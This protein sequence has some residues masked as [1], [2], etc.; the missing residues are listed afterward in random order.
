MKKLLA[1]ILCAF[2]VFSLCACTGNGSTGKKVIKWYTVT[3]DQKDQDAVFEKFNEELGEL[4]TGVEVEFYRGELTDK[5]AS[6]MAA[7]EQIDIAWTGYSFNMVDQILKKSYQPLDELI[8][9]YAPNIQQEIKDY[10]TEYAS[11]SYQGTLYA[12]PNVQPLIKESPMIE[13][14][15]SLWEFF[16]AEAFSAARAASPY[17]TED[18]LKVIDDYLVKV[19]ASGLMDSDTVSA[20]M[21]IASCVMSLV[22]RGYDTV[23]GSES[24]PY[25]LVYKAFEENPEIVPFCETDE[26]KLF[27][28]YAAKWFDNGYISEDYLLSSGSGGER[29]DTLRCHPTSGWFNLSDEVNGVKDVNDEDGYVYAK[30]IL[31][32]NKDQIFDG[33]NLTGSSATYLTIPLTAK[34]SVEAIK[35]LDLL[36]SDEGTDLL[37]LLIYGFEKN[38]DYAKEY[39][40]YHYTL[41]GDIA[42]GNGYAIQPS[43][44]ND[45]GIAHW[46]VGNVFLCYRTSNILDGQKEYAEKYFSETLSN[47]HK[48]AYQGFEPD[49]QSWSAKLGQMS[50][51]ASEYSDTLHAGVLG[52]AKY[53]NSYN[54]MITK[55][56]AASLEE[57]TEDINNQAKEYKAAQ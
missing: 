25:K 3:G 1:V 17:L 41:E 31:V 30:Q 34:Y 21:D 13:I 44:S 14:P 26:Y 10:P 46:V 43:E 40:N 49:V 20:T 12:I 52:S 48:T 8:E 24:I 55:L 29:L 18:M 50:S 15:I 9:K 19:K 37:N 7:G 28:K 56:N 6:W 54:N 23:Y 16:D 2:M 27:I 32:R 22:T 57:F 36:R 51:A 38:S 33:V 5:W 39:G 42:Y 47:A 53:L 45:Y 4:M 11:G 35:L